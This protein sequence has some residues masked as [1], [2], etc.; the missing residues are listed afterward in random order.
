LPARQR[1]RIEKVDVAWATFHK[2]EDDRLGFAGIVAHARSERIHR[3]GLHGFE[4]F[5]CGIVGKQTRAAQQGS[6]S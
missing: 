1:L 6:R 3:V 2:K 4:A 5:L